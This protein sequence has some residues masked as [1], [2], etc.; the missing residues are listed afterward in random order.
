[1]KHVPHWQWLLAIY[2]VLV[3]VP[4]YWVHVKAK[5]KLLSNK[6]WQNIVAY[7]SLVIGVGVL[8][9]FLTMFF[10]YQFLFAQ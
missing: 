1:M 6:N 4:V 3:A 7:F 9:N 2:F 8:M 10:Y 5:Q